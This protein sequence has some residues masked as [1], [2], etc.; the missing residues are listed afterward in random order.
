[1]NLSSSFHHNNVWTTLAWFEA[2]SIKSIAPGGV[3]KRN[4]ILNSHI[5]SWW[6]LWHNPY[7]TKV[8]CIWTG[9][10]TKLPGQSGPVNWMF[11]YTEWSWEWSRHWKG[12][13]G[14]FSALGMIHK[15]T[16]KNNNIHYVSVRGNDVQR[17]T[18]RD[19]QTDGRVK[20]NRRTD[21]GQTKWRMSSVCCLIH[22]DTDWF[23]CYSNNS[24]LIGWI[25]R[26]KGGALETLQCSM[27]WWN[28]CL[29]TKSQWCLFKN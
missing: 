28:C 23:I 8:A 18:W 5:Y 21:D 6:H 25:K 1:M 27:F 10:K 13:V 7:S 3:N 29:S 26:Q 20:A 14:E 17:R 15:R 12:Q 19:T 22:T 9:S 2:E 4:L 16:S 11:S 24:D